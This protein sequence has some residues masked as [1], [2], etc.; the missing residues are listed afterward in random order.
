[1]ALSW[2]QITNE[3]IT[4]WFLYGQATKPADLVSDQ[5][6]RPAD[7]PGDGDNIKL[8]LDMAS[9]MSSGPGRFAFGSNSALVKAFMEGEPIAGL[10]AGMEYTQDEIYNKFIGSGYNP[11]VDSTKPD[12]TTQFSMKQMYY[13]DGSPDFGMRTYIYNTQ[14]FVISKD[15]RFVVDANGTRHIK[16]YAIYALQDNFDFTGGVPIVGPI[17]ESVVDPSHIGRTVYMD[18]LNPE[19]APTKDYYVADF[20]MDKAKNSQYFD[21]GHAAVAIAEAG[22]IAIELFSQGNRVT[23]ALDE[24]NRPILYGTDDNNA[25]SASFTRDEAPLLFDYKNNGVVLIGGDGNDVLTGGDHSDLLIGGEGYS[26]YFVGNGDRI[27]DLPTPPDPAIKSD[28]MVV[29]DNVELIGGTKRAGDLYY[30]DDRGNRFSLSGTTLTVENINTNSTFVIENFKNHDLGINLEQL[31][32]NPGIEIGPNTPIVERPPVTQPI[33]TPPPPVPGK[34]WEPVIIVSPDGTTFTDS[35]KRVLVWPNSAP[36]YIDP[37]G[38]P[39]KK[40]GDKWVPKYT[41]PAGDGSSPNGSTPTGP[42]KPLTDPTPFPQTGGPFTDPNTPYTSPADKDGNG[43]P[44]IHEGKWQTPDPKTKTWWERARDFIFRRDPLTFDLDGDGL[45]TI[46][47][48]STAPILFDH[49]GDGIKNGTGW[50]KS[51]DGFL[52]LDRNGN[53]TIDN[54][55]ELFGDSTPLY[56]GGKAADG[57]AALAQED[58]NHDGIVNANDAHFADLRIW[59]DLNQDGESQANELFKLDELDIIGINVASTDHNQILGNGNQLADTGSFIKADGVS[60]T[61]GAVSGDLGDINL[62]HDT[63]HREFPDHLDTSTVINLPDMQGSGAVR[64]LQEAATQS[65]SLKNLL[66]QYAATTTRDAQ[67]A[68]LDSILSAWADTSGYA[69]SYAD[70]LAGIEFTLEDFGG[71]RQVPYTVSYEAF[72]S[73]TN[74]TYIDTSG[75]YVTSSGSGGGGATLGIEVELTPEYQ[76][77]INS[78]NKK[79]HILEAFNGSY[80]FGLPTQP[81]VGAKTGITFSSASSGGGGSL[82]II[83]SIPI[84]IRYAQ[85]QLDFLQQ[86]YDALKESVYDSLLLQTRLRPYIDSVTMMID[87]G[88]IYLNFTEMNALLAQ[89]HS[90]NPAVAIGDILDLRRVL[91]DTLTSEGWAGLEMLGDWLTVD[92]SNP[93]VLATLA[94]FGYS[95]IR[96]NANGALVES[97]SHSEMVVGKIGNDL[98]LGNAGNDLLIAGKGDDTLSGGTGNDILHGGEGND[99]YVFNIGDGA[100]IVLET[101]GYSGDDILQF[102]AGISTGDLSISRDSDN[103]V[104]SLANGK[105][106]VTIQHWFANDGGLHRLDTISFADGRM[107]DL[108]AMQIGNIGSDNLVGT[109]A[110]DILFGGGG[111]DTLTGGLGDDWLSGGQ[112]ADLM[113]GGEGNDI[114]AVDNALDQVVEA[115]GE[116]IDLVESTISYAL[117]DTLENLNLLGGGATSGTGNAFD[118]VIN[119]NN[120][121]NLLQGMAG[122]DNLSGG[123]G[124]DTLDGGTGSD[125]M[126][127][128]GSNDTYIVDNVDDTISEAAIQ[129]KD[130]VKSSIT[131]TLGENLENLILTGSENLAGLGNSLNNVITGNSGD[132]LLQGLDGNDILDGDVGSDTLVGGQGNDGYIVDNINDLVQENAGEG[133]DEVKSSI[134]YTLTE[135]VENLTLTGAANLDG[136]GNISDNVIKGNSGNNVLTGFEGN[137]IL[138]GAGGTDTLIGGTGNDTYIIDNINDVVIE[139]AGEGSDTV[140]SSITYTLADTLENLTLIGGEQINATGNALNNVLVGNSVNNVLDGGAGADIMAGSYGNDTYILD[141]QADVVTELS[142][143]GNDTVI[144]PFDYTLTANAE[145]LILTGSALNGTGNNSDNLIVGTTADNTLIGLDGKDSLDGGAGADTLVG[146]T[147]DDTYMVDTLQDSIIE[148]ADEG[149]D[150]VQSNLTWTLTDNFENLTLTGT[151]DISGTGNAA[152]NIIIGNSGINTLVSLEGN[153]TLD[154]GSGADVMLGGVGNDTYVVDNAEDFVEEN[155]DAGI[156][157]V[158]SSVTHTLGNNFENL[159]LTGLVAINGNGNELNNILVGNSASNVLSGLDGDDSL[160]GGAGADTLIGGAGNDTYTVDNAGDVVQESLAEGLDRVRASVSHTLSSN[161]ENLTLTGSGNISGIGN[162]LA[163]TITGNS[164]NNSLSGLAGDDVLIGNS[165]NDTLDGGVGADSMTGGQGGDTYVVDN[166]G[167]IVNENANEGVDLVQA[168]ISY[169]LGANLENLQLTGVADIDGTGNSTQNTILANGGNNNLFGLAGNDKLI[170]KEGNDLLD[171][172]TGTDAMIGGT[173]D[174][175]YVVDNAE[176]VVVELAGEGSDTVQSSISYTL[177]DTLENLTLT[178]SNAISGTG[179]AQNN[180]INGNAGSNLLDGKAG[181]D[182]MAGGTG[183]DT[184]IVNETGDIVIEDTNAGIDN[185]ESTVSY[186]LTKN[187]EN[188]TFTGTGNL[189]GIGNALNNTITGTDGDNIL[190][191]GA[192]IDNLAAGVGNDVYIVDNTADTIVE[193]AGE[194]TDTV[195]SS[196]DYT[197][198]GNIENLTLT[199]IA[200]IKGTGNV[201]DNTIT[202]NSGINVLTGGAGNDTYIVDNTAD[203]IVE[204]AGEGTDTVLSSA[205]YTLSGNIENLILTGEANID[206]TGSAQN[207]TL[208][209]NTGDNVLDGAAGADVMAGDAGNDTYIVDNIS[210]VVTEVANAGID[211]IQSSVSYT[212]AA[213]VENMMLTGAADI[214]ATG[215]TLDNELSGN[216]GNNQL[217]GLAGN[218]TLAGNQ[219][220]DLLDGGSGTDTMAGSAGNDTYVVDNAGDVVSENV[221]EGTDTVQSGISYTLTDNVENLTLTGTAAINGTGNALDNVITGNSANNV[222]DGGTGVDTMS[223]GSGNDTYVVDSNA[224]VVVEGLNAG[225]DTVLASDTYTLSTNV[226]NLTLTGTG[227]INGIGNALAN[228]IT[229]NSGLNVLSG[230]AGN[231][232]YLVD[233]TDDVVVENANEGTDL[234][235]SSATYTLLDNVEN[236]TLAGTANIDGTGNMLANTIIGNSGNNVI[237][238]GTG[239][240]TMSGGTGNDTYIVDNSGDVVTEAASAGTDLVYSSVNYTLTTNVENLTLTATGNVNGTG[241]VLNNIILGNDGNNVLD[242]ATG[243]DTMLGGVGNDTYMVDNAGDIVTENADEGIDTVQSSVTHTLSSNVENLTLTGTS[244]INGNGNALNNLI[245]GN[246]GNNILSGMAGNDTLTGNAGTDILDGGIDADTMAGNAGNDTYVVDNAGD[247]VTE[248]LNEGTDLVQSSITYTLTNNVENL[249]LTG[250]ASIDGTGNTLANVIIGNSGANILDG[251]AGDDNVAAGAGNDTLIGDDG[252][253]SLSGEAGIDTISGNAGNDTLN[254]GLDA[255]NMTGGIGNDIY[256]VDNAGDMV[257]ENAAEGIDLVQSSI[258][259]TLTDNVE[260]LTLTGSAAINGTGNMLNNI[261]IGNS[262]VNTLYGLEGDDTLDGATGADAMLG[263]VGNDTYIVDNAGDVVV[264]AI[265]EGLDLVQA[266]V[267]YTLSANAENLT[268]TGTGNINGTGNTLN[269]TIIGNS[270][271]NVLSGL[272]GNDILTGNVGNDTL[273]GGLDADTMSGGVG[274]DTYVVDN[275]GDLVTENLNEGTDIVQSSITYA[276][277]NNVENLTLTGAAEIDGTGNTLNNIIIGNSGINILDGG[278]GDD[279]INAGAGTDILVGGDGND[280]LS[281]EAGNDTLSGN[282]GNDT[283]NGGLDADTMLGGIGNDTYVVDNVGDL[284]TENLNEG[285]DLVQ[286]TITYTLTDNVE[287]LTLTG[288]TSINGTGNVLNNVIIGNSGANTLIGLDGND[289]L[290]GGTGAD[291]M[292]GGMDNDTYVVDNVADVVVENVGEG[293]D[294]VQSTVSYTLSANV[295]NLTLTGTGNINGTGNELNNIILGNSGNNVLSGLAGNDTLTGNAGIDTLDGGLDADTMAGNAGNDTYVVDNVG[296][297]VIENASEGTDLVQASI[298]HTLSTNVENLTLTGIADIN[299]TGNTLA[300]LITGNSGNNI[301]DGGVGVDTMIGGL[302]DDTYIV[303]NSSDVITENINGGTDSVLS[304]VTYTLSANIENLTLTGTANINGTGNVNNNLILGNSGANTLSGDAGNDILDGGLGADLLLGGVGDDTYIIE[305]TGDSVLEATNAGIDSVLSSITYTLT[306][307]VENL[308]LTSAGNISGTG[309]ILNNVILGNDANNVLSGLAGNDTLVGNGGNDTLNGGLDIDAMSGGTGDDTYIVDNVADTVTENLDEGLDSVQS[310]VTYTLSS[311][312]EN[313]TLTGSGNING[314]GNGLNNLLTGNTGNNVLSGLAGTDTLIGNAGNDTLDGGLDAD[315]MAGGQGNDVYVVD[316][317]G[318]IVTEALNEGTDLVQSGITYTLTNNV[319]NLTL[320]GTTDI[321]G[322]GNALANIITGNSGNNILNGLEGN[323]TLVGAIGDDVLNGGYGAD[324]MAG[325]AG[326]DFYQVDDAGDV[327]TEALNEGNDTVESSI[328]YNLTANV[329]NLFLTGIDN[330]NGTGNALD[331]FIV[332]N[333]GNNVLDGSL[334]ADKLIGGTGND[335]YIIDNTDDVIVEIVDEGV[336]T[337]LASASYALS[338]NVENLT[339]TGSGNINGMGNAMDNVITGNSGNNFLSGGAGNDTYLVDSTAD[340]VAENAE[341][342]TD[343]VYSSA[344]YSLTANIENLNLTGTTDINATGNDL[345]NLINGTSGDNV[346]DGGAGADTLNGGDGNDTYVVD[347][348]GDVVTESTAAGI[349]TVQSGIDY[350][351]GS[352]LENLIL[353]NGAIQGHGNE[354]DNVITGNSSGNVLYGAGGNDTLNGGAGSDV[355]DGGTGVN[356]LNGDAGDDT[357]IIHS[358]SDSVFE[359]AELGI[360]TVKAEIDY[361]LGANIENL[362]LEDGAIE[363]SGNN[364]NNILIGNDA[365]NVLSGLAGNDTLVGNGGNDTL[366]GG[367]DID[368]MSGGTGD[369]T[370]I[371]DNIADTLTENLDEGLDNVQ[372]SVTYTLSSNVENLTL[373]GSGSGSGNINGT[374]N[375]LNNILTGNTGNNVLSGLAGADTLIG[376]AGNDTLDGGLDADSMAGGQGNDVYVVDNAGDIVTEAAGE[377]I[378]TVQASVNYTLGANLE[379]LVLTGDA[380][381]GTG[382]ALNNIITANDLGDHLSGATGDDSLIGGFGN[383]VLDGGIGADVM[384]GS[385]GDDTYIINESGDQVVEAGNGGIDTIKA[386]INYILNEQVENLVLSGSATQGVGNALNNHLTGNDLGNTLFGEAGDDI[387]VSGAGNDQL[388]G[389]VDA[390]TMSGGAGN[391]TYYVDNINDVIVEAFNAGT[392]N[393]QSSVTYTL[394]SNTENLVLTGSANLT[395]TGNSLD[396]IIQGNNGDNLLDGAAGADS[397]SGGLGNDIYVVDNVLDS[398]VESLFGG[399]DTVVSSINYVLGDNFENLTLTGIGSLTA[400]GNNVANILQG[401]SG[402]NLLNGGLG[403]D[404]MAGGAGN[405]IYVVDNAGDAIFEAANEGIDTVQASV[406]Y[407]ASANVENLTLTGFAN[408]NAYGNSLANLING[409]GGNNVLDGADGN[410]ILIG[411]AGND[412]LMGGQGNDTYYYNLGDGLDEIVEASGIDTMRF[413]IGMSLDNISMRVVNIDGQNVVQLR[414]LDA[415]GLEIETQG[416]NFAITNDEND[417]IVSPIEKFVFEDGEELV[418]NDLLVKQTTLYG[419]NK[420]ET[421]IG[422][423][424]DNTIFGG[425]GQDTI[426][427]Y[428]ANDVLFGEDGNDILYGGLGKDKLYGGNGIDN[429]YGEAG[430]DLLDGGNGADNLYGGNGNDIMQGMSGNDLLSD[431]V[432][433]NVFDGGMDI[434]SIIAGNANDLIIGGKGNDTL[435]TG[436]GY[437]VIS[438]NKGDGQDIINASVGADNTLSLGGNFAYSD[439]SL[440]KTGNNLILKMGTTDQITLKDWYLGT[441]NHSVVN[442]QVIAEAIQGFSLGSADNLRNNR[443]EN[444]NFTNLVAAFDASGATSNWKLTDT[445]LTAHLQAGSDTAAIGGDLAYQYGKNSSLAGMGVL[446]VQSV[447]AAASFGQTAQTLNSPTVWQAE[448]AKLA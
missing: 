164:G 223:G 447:I 168:S 416:F 135:N 74:A 386:S 90:S 374:G 101:H 371:V 173:G 440:T 276:L 403:A 350:T 54:G 420:S 78:W 373:T 93:A 103:L 34:I 49:D 379:N 340:V 17:G 363:G 106:Q 218:D 268:L 392:D 355:L 431:T 298:N 448:V 310:S 434:D 66:T 214:N 255:D 131:Y 114:Y 20:N 394:S 253:D 228:I 430:N 344:T 94:E 257:I 306:D 261:V 326:N 67:R 56:A 157:I 14:A 8:I 332:G 358:D 24:F 141:N 160:D 293:I 244:S 248:N 198:S 275:A 349:D 297:V 414:L 402:N 287:N 154:G 395:G 43:I 28:G 58:T 92:A 11:G 191:G 318:D 238:G 82:T 53:G 425:T 3:L 12:R 129:G 183:N 432:G 42:V 207:N 436:T 256:V 263:G 136:M 227:D 184:Y 107:L 235:Q 343:T 245:V 50:I 348:A 100:D 215:N 421:L 202:G 87:S 246:G 89:L 188:L 308:T 347:N 337:V 262:G 437:D 48:S 185:V 333:E 221:D 150:T 393:V 300:N 365:A 120:G 204:N 122:N 57:F 229:A 44:D 40:D 324:N 117:S 192:G 175:T 412:L 23:R 249:T 290:D 445:R 444:F 147:G 171:G 353:V 37:N 130:T 383:D 182:T 372:S 99:T 281:G 132:N 269:N 116:G 79:I 331:N 21:V 18:F 260:N 301:I 38:M 241:N 91:G 385:G 407:T 410:D 212:L 409:N 219:G 156:D 36:H 411:S 9:F 180:V 247:L 155:A 252:N 279:T 272:A 237:D 316:N 265:D 359:G 405:D 196:A 126:A 172:G 271:S 224:D 400:T 88:G 127:G 259:Y 282:T 370:Y 177:A 98:L 404:T 85:Q 109:D 321:N 424:N 110:N 286:S 320:T 314:T 352:N 25:M 240:D 199:G 169:T 55:T 328:S 33:Y 280:S 397:M 367:L 35:G 335:T 329:E 149:L 302:G 292:L 209:G 68:Q 29:F 19:S 406:T 376:N 327:I 418:V 123:A 138:D 65:T 139:N 264:E 124:D 357:Y 396:N 377:G 351:L 283:L 6:I 309:N 304:G 146:G 384:M 356:L 77:L 242:G 84:N 206:G 294:I 378:D 315:N 75:T 194:G 408:I 148:L 137:D 216:T 133:I 134:S 391:D 368:A 381:S 429:L 311:N 15:A 401:N 362:I 108:N 41:P 170:G 119:G 51:D 422:D 325:G 83:N 211:T 415:T 7:K 181:A 197:L 86:S 369:D 413:G 232:T 13:S 230:G 239:A 111:D 270:G 166:T 307:N 299:G 195:L 178:G 258:T 62:A 339:L 291:T 27:I 417:D 118:N 193:N 186:T 113:V 61:V 26:S 266:S 273:D 81:S 375:G 205:D 361:I 167:D 278:L 443:I 346:L 151:A 80:F 69:K 289:T 165:G 243:A 95:G 217:F 4:N 187:V 76:A 438:F 179:N 189:I 190:D 32:L 47:I 427:G 442:L 174:D 236:L 439:L 267:T 423:R 295:E 319:E 1:M 70:R 46:G 250:T 104:I 323:D 16:N 22:A 96:L 345:D 159:T 176:D 433:K 143:Q 435:T 296:D 303:D 201:L 161:V 60:G 312:V 45:E 71:V 233:S 342:G 446:N 105:D 52:V 226:E 73:I 390:D 285:T 334:G 163:N 39:I 317:T 153:D 254:G 112:G 231:D 97:D 115:D 140:Q 102:G 162:D 387:L 142:G 225:T 152:D 203:A 128:G 364:L 234:V 125:A 380:L 305:N 72:G 313:L 31:G 288:A 144:S 158:K 338:N 213:N 220:N 210:D 388:D 398:A 330:L 322:T 222:I 419:T 277:T 59:R 2:S 145:N 208:I 399:T 64:D 426:Y 428:S 5:W 341:E 284:V 274:N 441:T 10:V 360:D 389:G 200:D 366:D 30:K 336:E 63:F 354:L 121:A 251:G 382:N